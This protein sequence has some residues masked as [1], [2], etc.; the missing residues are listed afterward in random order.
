MHHLGERSITSMF[1]SDMEQKPDTDWVPTATQRGYVCITCDCAMISD[2]AI[3]QVL[4]KE[5]ARAIFFGNHFADS[6]KWDQALWLLKHWDAIRAYA[7]GMTP[8]QLVR[9]NKNG[10][11]VSVDPG[12]RR[13]VPPKRSIAQTKQKPL[14]P[15]D[16]QHSLA[17]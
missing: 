6:K 16:G 13:R 4:V 2:L 7:E 3:A 15:S 11:I 14:A 5:N 12:R 1:G 17:I 9:V 8:G 10:R